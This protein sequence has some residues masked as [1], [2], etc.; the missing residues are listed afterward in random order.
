MKILTTGG[1]R[2]LGEALVKNLGAVSI[3]RAT[4]FDITKDVD[5]IVTKSLEYDVFI[6]NAFDG[7]PQ[8]THANFGQS[9][10]LIKMFNTWKENNKKGFIFNIG[11]I[12]SDDI[13]APEPSWET[14]RVSKKSL[15]AASL[16]CSRAFRHNQVLFRT[17]LIKPDRLDTELSRSRGNWTGNGIDCNDIVNFIN[18]CFEMKE[19][20]QIDQVTVSLNYEHTN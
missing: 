15:E 9:V 16:Q 8:E 18:Y 11:S 3:S 7:P 12:A 10:L 19:N 13:V 20:S 17:T 6:N 14:Y 1:D 2:G 5:A 4:G